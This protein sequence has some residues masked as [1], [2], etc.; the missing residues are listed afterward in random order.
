RELVQM[1]LGAGKAVKGIAFDGVNADGWIGEMLAQLEGRRAF[2]ELEPA[3]NFNGLLR[4]Y[5]ARGYSWLS[6]LR[7]IDFGACLADDMGLGKTV[8]TLAM[9]Q[10]DWQTNEGKNRRP[11]LLVC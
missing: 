6:F 9:I 1:S 8:Q 5:Q 7:G 2:H 4:P 10:R 3:A 11:A